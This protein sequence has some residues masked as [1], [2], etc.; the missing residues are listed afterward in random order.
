MKNREGK[1]NASH[2]EMAGLLKKKGSFMNKF[3]K[4]LFLGILATFL[5]VGSVVAYPYLSVVAYPHLHDGSTSPVP[6]PATMLLFGVGLIGFVGVTRRI[7][8]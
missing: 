6:E 3:L 1:P 2:S 4:S 8:K 7:I 5:V